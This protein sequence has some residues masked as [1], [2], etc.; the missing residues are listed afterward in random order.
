MSFSTTNQTV[1]IVSLISF[2]INGNAEHIEPGQRY[3]GGIEANTIAD[4]DIFTEEYN[5]GWALYIDNDALVSGG[6]LDRDYTG[7]IGFTLSGT[8]A[9]A[10]M[11]SL[12]NWRESLTKLI[13]IDA[14]YNKQARFSLHS[15]SF[16]LTLFTPGNLSTAA[17][18][19]NDHPYASYLYI[20]NTEAMVVPKSN[21]VY[22]TILSI[23]FLGLDLAGDVQK[24]LHKALG[25][26]K[27]LGWDNQISSGGELTAKYTLSA[28][29]LIARVEG[30][31]YAKHELKITSEANVGFVTN[32]ALGFNWRWGRIT[33]PWW[34]F[35]PHLSDYIN[36]GVPVVNETE[37]THA[38]EVYLW[39][40]GNVQ[41]RIYNAILQGQFRDSAVTFDDDEI[42]KVTA[43]FTLGV[44]IELYDDLRVSIFQRTRSAAL[45]LPNAP[46]PQWFGFTVSKSY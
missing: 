37:K 46:R 3:P 29:K 26:E 14:L 28:Q 6:G 31:Q 16:G 44:A 21:I 1:L 38:P 22:Q 10:Y 19:F 40:G 9:T 30:S 42:E 23:G 5:T 8:R 2:A 7:G 35:N 24:S 32:V 43:E 17:P 27:P 25:A 39:V 45:K 34:S 41:Y 13:S 18:I 12:D 4:S 15:F 20:S 11:L 33:T 36:M